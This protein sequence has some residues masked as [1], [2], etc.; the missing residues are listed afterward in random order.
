MAFPENADTIQ[1]YAQFHIYF[2]FIEKSNP[3]PY[4]PLLIINYM[5]LYLRIRTF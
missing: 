3:I 2:Y 1:D 4:T 5:R